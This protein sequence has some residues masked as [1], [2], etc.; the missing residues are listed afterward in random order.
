M[1]TQQTEIQTTVNDGE[2][3]IVNALFEP[4]KNVPQEAKDFWNKYGVYIGGGVALIL[5][6]K[7]YRKFK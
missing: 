5:G 6:W 7:I 4:F 1:A 3:D 2:N